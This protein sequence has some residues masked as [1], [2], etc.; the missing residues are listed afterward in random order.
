[1]HVARLT[2]VGMYVGRIEMILGCVSEFFDVFN[3]HNNSIGIK[4]CVPGVLW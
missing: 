1:M 4:G 2:T 3:I